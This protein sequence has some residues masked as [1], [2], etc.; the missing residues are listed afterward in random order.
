MIAVQDSQ[1]P[2]GNSQEKALANVI[3]PKIEFREAT[4]GSAFDFLK[5]AIAKASNGAQSVNF[6]LK[7]PPELVNTATITLNLTNI[8]ATEA[9]KYISELANVEVA[10]DKYAISISPKGGAV[11]S[12]TPAPPATPTTPQIPGLPQ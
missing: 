7:L 10:Y 11:V 8:P 9:I 4:I 12:T 1:R 5:N 6:V 2:K 3:I